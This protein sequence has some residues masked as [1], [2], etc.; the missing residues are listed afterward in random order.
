[1]RERRDKALKRIAL[2]LTVAFIMVTMLAA[3]AL[4]VMASNGAEASGGA[5]C[6]PGTLNAHASVPEAPQ[7]QTAHSNI[8]EC[9]M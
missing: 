6:N 4:P 9:E 1:M 2:V 5:A 3:S 7:T 8:P